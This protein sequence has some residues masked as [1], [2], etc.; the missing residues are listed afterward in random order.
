MSLTSL[1]MCISLSSETFAPFRSFSRN[2]VLLA[3]FHKPGCAT[4]PGP[5]L[6]VGLMVVAQSF[7]LFHPPPPK[8]MG[9]D[10][11]FQTK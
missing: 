8:E 11:D 3:I 1:L 2:E 4:A 5:D 10:W 9:E 6:Q 7:P